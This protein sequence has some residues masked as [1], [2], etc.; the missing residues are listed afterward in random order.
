MSSLFCGN[1]QVQSI[2][3]GVMCFQCTQPE[4]LVDYWHKFFHWYTLSMAQSFQTASV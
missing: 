1:V 3:C 2:Y 4:V